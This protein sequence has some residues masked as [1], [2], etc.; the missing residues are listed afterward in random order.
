MQGVQYA[1]QIEVGGLQLVPVQETGQTVRE[2]AREEESRHVTPAD[3]LRER[4]PSPFERFPEARSEPGEVARAE[5]RDMRVLRPT[6]WEPYSYSPQ[7]TTEPKAQAIGT[8]GLL[9]GLTGGTN[10]RRDSVS[11]GPSPHINP[12]ERSHLESQQPGTSSQSKPP[13]RPVTPVK[14]RI[15]YPISPGGTEIKPPPGPR[16]PPSKSP[17]R[18]A[19]ASPSP[20]RP[21]APA[22]PTEVPESVSDLQKLT[23]VLE[24]A[25]KA[26]RS[27]DSRVE[28]V[29]AV[30]DL[31]RLE[32]KDNEK[33]LTPLIAGDWLAVI[34]PSLRDLSAHASQW[35]QEV[36]DAAHTYYGKWL[37]SSPI[38]R[39][40]MRPERPGRFEVGQFVRVEQRAISLLL[41]AVPGQVKEDVVAMRKMTSI[42]II[43]TILTTYQPGGLRERSALLRYLTS[44]ESSKTVAEALKGVRRWTRW[45]NRAAE[46][47]V[48]IPDAT[49]L[50]AG[51]DVL[52]ASVF[53]QYPEV[54]FR[55]QTFR[56]QHSVD[57]IPTQDKAVS[58]ALVKCFK[59]SC[60]S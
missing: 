32:I 34:S 30:P 24:G 40:L 26:N 15:V 58:L 33:E 16:P 59:Q 5:L 49:L 36:Q 6:I 9:Y 4:A 45:R 55:L 1:W 13:P 46:L 19:K 41:K 27:G 23:A 51:L 22:Y 54:H 18:A 20:P 8:Q 29:K 17:K 21:R 44:P 38:D 56:H 47:N 25:F 52:T 3:V 39:L 12:W 53:T 57:H 37:E 10:T 7:E 60:R 11:R 2:R 48:A 28:D 14:P 31:P 50:I 42:E 35:W 43:G